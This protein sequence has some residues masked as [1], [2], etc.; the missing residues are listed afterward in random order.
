MRNVITVQNMR[1]S[2]AHTIAEYVPSKE[3]MY[4]AAMGVFKAVDWTRGPIGILVG[5][6]NNGGDG[7]ALACILA[8][9]G[10][11]CRVFRVSEKF[12]GII[13]SVWTHSILPCGSFSSQTSTELFNSLTQYAY[14]SFGWNTI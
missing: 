9:R 13:S 8:D 10:I 12:S 11:P 3:L 2:D 14:C 1:E 7:Y 5:A 6:G 4:R